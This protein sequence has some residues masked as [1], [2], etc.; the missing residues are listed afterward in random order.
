MEIRFH[1]MDRSEALEATVTEKVTEVID[2]VL[3]RHDGHVQVWL[4]AETNRVSKGTPHFI[5]EVEVRFPPRK[6]LFV[7]RGNSDMHIAINEVCE[8]LRELLREEGKREVKQM[9]N[10]G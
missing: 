6:D 9:R 5:C 7:S 2:D 10:G 3:H 8:T 4:I 1:H